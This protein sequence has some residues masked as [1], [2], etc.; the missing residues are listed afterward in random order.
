[1]STIDSTSVPSVPPREE[2]Q[3]TGWTVFAG[4]MLVII[5]CLDALYGLAAVLNSE[6]VIVGGHGV[7]VADVSTWG[8]VHLI[9]GMLVAGTGVGLFAAWSPARWAGV[10]FIAVNAIAQIVWFP[11]AP[12]WACL[13]IALDVVVIYQL[14]VRWEE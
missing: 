3:P 10:F 6:V 12:L 7:I 13:M 9:I 8:W 14:T 2:R 4:V 11:A 5:G 1:M